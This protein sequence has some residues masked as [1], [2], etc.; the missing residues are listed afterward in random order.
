VLAAAFGT[1][2]PFAALRRFRQVSETLRTSLMPG[3]GNS[4]RGSLDDAGP[5]GMGGYWNCAFANKV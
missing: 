5:R 3:R 4:D 1:N 2:R